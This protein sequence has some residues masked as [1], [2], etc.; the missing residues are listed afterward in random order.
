MAESFFSAAD[1]SQLRWSVHKSA[2][3]WYILRGKY[4]KSICHTRTQRAPAAARV[5]Q[6]SHFMG[7]RV[8]LTAAALYDA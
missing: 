4:Y 5:A 1:E 7:T 6:A 8:I 2:V 3:T